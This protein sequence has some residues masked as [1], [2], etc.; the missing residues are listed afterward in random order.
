MTASSGSLDLSV[1]LSPIGQPTISGETLLF[2]MNLTGELTG[3]LS[4]VPEPSS[5][6]TFA[7]VCVLLPFAGGRRPR[8]RPSVPRH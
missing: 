7:I 1:E 8:R 2:T 4:Q 3:E 5:W 6:A